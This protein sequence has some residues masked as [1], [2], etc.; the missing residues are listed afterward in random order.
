MDSTSI[1]A[2]N[3]PCWGGIAQLFADGQE[4][5]V[6]FVA[7]FRTGSVGKAGAAA[8]AA[9]AVKGELADNQHFTLDSFQSQV[10]LAVFILENT[11]TQGFFSQIAAFLF[12]IVGADTQQDQKSLADFSNHLAIDGDRGGFDSC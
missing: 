9:V 1:S 5:F 8:L 12:G 2:P 11:Q 10:H 3:R 4:F 7:Q 6:Q